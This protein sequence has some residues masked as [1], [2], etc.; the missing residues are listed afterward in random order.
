MTVKELHRLF[1]KDTMFTIIHPEGTVT[2]PNDARRFRKFLSYEIQ[3]DIE[4]ST[5]AVEF[6]CIPSSEYEVNVWIKY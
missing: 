2:T 5:N 4:L 1:G 6:H 3:G